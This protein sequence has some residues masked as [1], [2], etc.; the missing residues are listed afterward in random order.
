V[1]DVGTWGA[2]ATAV[3]A[4]VGSL[5]GLA[6]QPA[7]V[8]TLRGE[9]K[10]ARDEVPE[11]IKAAGAAIL[12]AVDGTMTQL[13]ADMNSLAK[14]VE[15]LEKWRERHRVPSPESVRAP[16]NSGPDLLA[17]KDAEHERRIAALEARTE[18]MD[19]GLQDARV[20]L[21]NILGKIDAYITQP[22]ASR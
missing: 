18:R 11:K 15:S 9:V 12:S 3:A 8:A 16:A 17:A 10:S 6:R 7:D 1:A 4:A 20:T 2:A 5:V 22:R 19:N 13:R 14:R 21:G